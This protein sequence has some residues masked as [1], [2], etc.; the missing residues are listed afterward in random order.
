MKWTKEKPTKTGHYYR[1]TL[2]A[3]VV[4]VTVRDGVDGLV[5]DIG[6]SIKLIEKFSSDFY[7]IGPM[8]EPPEDA[9]WVKREQNRKERK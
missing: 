4:A 7:W 3:R 6:D 1:T 8:P 2:W 9:D 5:G